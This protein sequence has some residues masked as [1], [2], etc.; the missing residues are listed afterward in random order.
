MIWKAR[1]IARPPADG[2]FAR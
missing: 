2:N 1:R